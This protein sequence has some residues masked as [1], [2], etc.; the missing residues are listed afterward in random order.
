MSHTSGG[1]APPFAINRQIA[2]VVGKPFTE[3]YDDWKGYLRD[4]Y[5][6]QEMA[7]ERRGLDHRPR[8]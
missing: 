2:K 7:A 3:L 5:G 6:M 1:Y 8:S 4:R